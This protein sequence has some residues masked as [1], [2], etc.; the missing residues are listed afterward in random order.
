MKNQY[1]SEFGQLAAQADAEVRAATNR[2]TAQAQAAMKDDKDKGGEQDWQRFG[3]ALGDWYRGPK[4]A[5][6]GDIM[7][8]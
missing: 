8:P 7:E 5:A 2:A 6:A 4:T 3:K 1:Y